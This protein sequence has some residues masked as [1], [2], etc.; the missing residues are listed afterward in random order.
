MIQNNIQTLGLIGLVLS[1]PVIQETDNELFIDGLQ[2]PE[3]CFDIG[4]PFI[5][6]LSFPV[7]LEIDLHQG[8]GRPCILPVFLCHVLHIVRFSVCNP[9]L[10]NIVKSPVGI[11][12]FPGRLRK[13]I[14]LRL[15]LP[16]E[17]AEQENTGNHHADRHPV[18][19]NQFHN[20]MIKFWFLSS[21]HINLSPNH[22]VRLAPV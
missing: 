3:Q 11:L 17:T 6:N 8:Q 15:H 7:V 5:R 1:I 10:I 20:R 19:Y 22:M 18:T 13:R 2:S 12:Y 9:E 4:K 21:S 14:T 16:V